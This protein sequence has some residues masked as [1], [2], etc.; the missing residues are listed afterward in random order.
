MPAKSEKSF[1][2]AVV[3]GFNRQDVLEYITAV[4]RDHKAE[5]EAHVIGADKLRAERDALQAEVG[6]LAGERAR[7]DTLASQNE[8]LRMELAELR[9]TLNDALVR[10]EEL[11]AEVSRMDARIVELEQDAQLLG[12]ARARANELETLAYRRAEQIEQ[13]AQQTAD[14]SRQQ[15]RHGVSQMK[16]K[17][18]ALKLDGE[19]AAYA[20]VCELDKMRDWFVHYG[21]VF[22]DVH[23]Q[24][25]QISP[26]EAPV[27]R[28]FVPQE[29]AES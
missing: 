26:G 25:A 11:R 7:A 29:F 18:D 5:A 3:G 20:I 2:T 10:E 22:D 8:T 19:Q 14:V 17:L 4:S 28:Q 6:A 15:L 12:D 16:A 21:D 23:A 9:S 27:V 13:E 24:I 1:R